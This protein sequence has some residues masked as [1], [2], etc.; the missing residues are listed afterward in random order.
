MSYYKNIW[1]PDDVS[2]A[3]L[4]SINYEKAINRADSIFQVSYSVPIHVASAAERD[5]KFPIAYYGAAVWRT[6]LGVEQRA[7]VDGWHTVTTGMMLLRP[8]DFVFGGS[9]SGSVGDVTDL[10][11]VTF[12]SK[13]S[14]YL[15]GIFSPAFRNYKIFF[16]LKSTSAAADILFQYTAD[17]TPDSSAVYSASDCYVN[18]AGTLT[19][20]QNLVKTYGTVM[21][22]AVGRSG[23]SEITLFSPSTTYPSH[24][25]SAS[26]VGN[27]PNAPVL[28][29]QSGYFNSASKSF[30][31]IVF[32]TSTGDM[33]GNIMI[34]GFN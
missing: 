16:N 33:T 25:V 5:A 12:T 4:S 13:A 2:S 14:V 21:G 24:R 10:G 18:S 19:T 17:G 15:N 11:V 26:V 29:N 9:T 31:G 6:D 28:Y 34:Y 30:D 20:T 3:S 22:G 1:Y 23:L 32:Y 8:D 7:M 27:T